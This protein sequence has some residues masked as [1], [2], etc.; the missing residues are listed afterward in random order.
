MAANMTTTQEIKRKYGSLQGYPDIVGRHGALLAD[1]EID[2][3]TTPHSTRFS[4]HG[5]ENNRMFLNWIN[6]HYG[7]AY[8]KYLQNQKDNSIASFI[9]RTDNFNDHNIVEVVAI[10]SKDVQ[11]GCRKVVA[12]VIFAVKPIYEDEELLFYSPVG[13]VDTRDPTPGTG[14]KTADTNEWV[15]S[16]PPRVRRGLQANPNHDKRFINYDNWFP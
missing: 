10:V 4:V 15:R 14:Y 8:Q 12:K 1:N 13:N 3:Q 9:Q 6:Q 5:Y 16:N 7:G 11:K 2:N